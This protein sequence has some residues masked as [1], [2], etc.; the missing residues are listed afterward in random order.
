MATILPLQDTSDSV[1]VSTLPC[2]VDVQVAP[3][4]INSYTC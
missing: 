4:M 1:V 3:I 2:L